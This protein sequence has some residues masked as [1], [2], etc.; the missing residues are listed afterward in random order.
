LNLGGKVCSP[1]QTLDVRKEVAKDVRLSEFNYYRGKTVM[2]QNL[3]LWQKVKDDKLK[4]GEAYNDHKKE[5]DK[6]Q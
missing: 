4:I 1:E 6:I 3:E 2:Q 5:S